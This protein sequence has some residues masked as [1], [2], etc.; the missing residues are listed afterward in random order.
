MK[1]GLGNIFHQSLNSLGMKHT[2]NVKYAVELANC[3]LK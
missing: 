1:P 3:A 2:K